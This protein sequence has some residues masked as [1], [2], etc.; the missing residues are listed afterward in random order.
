MN[1]H[2]G[3]VDLLPFS[4]LILVYRHNRI[5]TLRGV[6]HPV[7]AEIVATGPDAATGDT[8]TADGHGE[9][10]TTACSQHETASPPVA[11]L[12]RDL[13]EMMLRHNGSDASH[14]AAELILRRF[15]LP[16]AW[17]NCSMYA[18]TLQNIM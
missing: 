14:P 9:D 2:L 17:Q 15:P 8:R 1:C 12:T 4:K 5:S 3:M 18:T 16:V 13:M 6:L 10:R 7:P 11:T